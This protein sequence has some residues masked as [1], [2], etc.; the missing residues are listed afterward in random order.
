MAMAMAIAM[1]DGQ[2][3]STMSPGINNG[4]NNS[5]TNSNNN[6]N[7]NNNNNDSNI[8]GKNLYALQILKGS[9]DR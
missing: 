1:L 7:T 6:S 5:N 4:D 9:T 3:L 2:W 8:V